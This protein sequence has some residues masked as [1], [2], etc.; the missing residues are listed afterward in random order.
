MINFSD[1]KCLTK[2]DIHNII[3]LA[4]K[5]RTQGQLARVLNQI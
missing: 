2:P 4:E 1:F 5:A 3:D